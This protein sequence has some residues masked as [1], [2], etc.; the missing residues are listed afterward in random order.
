HRRVAVTGL[1]AVTALGPDVDAFDRGLRDGRSAIGP[2]TLFDA[3]AFRTRIAAQVRE[4]VA[5]AEVSIAPTSRPDG[6]G[7]Q[8]AVDAAR[9]GLTLGEG[10]AA[11]VL[12]D[13][14]FARA[15]GADILGF[16]AGWG[17]TADAYHM[18]APHPEG[19]G[20]ARAMQA[21]LADAALAPEAI[22]YVNAH[23]T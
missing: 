4:P 8:A 11:V 19:D 5:A 10:A 21:A 6:F 9:R 16:L 23:G 13:E 18:T 3:A 12:E 20:A 2:V 1:G 7:G 17:V 14:A 15:R 22:G